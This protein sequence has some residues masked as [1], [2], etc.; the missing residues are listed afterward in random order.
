LDYLNPGEKLG[1][2]HTLAKALRRHPFLEGMSSAHLQILAEYATWTEFSEN[3]VIFSEG[4]E[5]NRFYLI[6]EGK[7]RVEA[8][9]LPGDESYIELLGPGDEL[10]WSWL[11]PPF[12]W[13]FTARAVTTTKA[14]FF[15][16]TWLRERCEKDTSLGYE[17]MKRTAGVVIDRLQATRAKLLHPASR[18]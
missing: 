17:L 14:V 15:Y 2:K 9:S 6:L 3:Y 16:G 10:G 18:Q 1:S 13:H 4:E 11:F 7:V 8:A 12:R 5:A